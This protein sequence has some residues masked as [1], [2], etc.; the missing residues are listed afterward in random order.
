VSGIQY[1]GGQATG[2]LGGVSTA[3]ITI[4]LT[5][6]LASTP[7]AG[8]FVLV[9]YCTG[10]ANRIPTLTVTGD[11]SGLYTTRTAFSADDNNDVTMRTS[12]KVM[13]ATPD[14]IITRAA[15]GNTS[16]H[17]TL[18]IRVYRAVDAATPFDVAEVL[19]TSVNTGL[20]DPDAITP[21]TA[22]AWI[23]ACGCRGT[24]TSSEADLISSDLDAFVAAHSPEFSGGF[25]SLSGVGHKTDWTS[26]AFNPAAWTGPSS[27]TIMAALAYTM[28]LRPSS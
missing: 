13:G 6:G 28:A 11:Q 22:G 20:P 8:D 10:N 5:G 26:G 14:T 19:F 25:R 16:D 24:P 1:D 17:G 23:V 4:S 2:F 21:S 9:V 7:A 15:T 27:S 18:H 3:D 12:Y